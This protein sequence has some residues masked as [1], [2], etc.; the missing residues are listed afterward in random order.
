MEILS[1]IGRSTARNSTKFHQ[2][3]GLCG[4]F[5]CLVVSFAQEGITNIETLSIEQLAELGDKVISTLKD[6]VKAKERWASYLVI[7]QQPQA[8]WKDLSGRTRTIFRVFFFFTP[9]A[10]ARS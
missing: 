4:T 7:A 6:R 2:G 8:I 1:R 10:L 5:A 9:D 3:A